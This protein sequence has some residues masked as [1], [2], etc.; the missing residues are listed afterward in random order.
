MI[1]TS[2]WVSAIGSVATGLGAGLG[3]WAAL[4][5]VN[6]WRIEALG[7][8]KAEL[9]EEVLA[10]FYRARDALI[11]ARLP[12]GGAGTDV[13]ADDGAQAAARDA[14][15]MAAP[16]E[17]LNQASQ[18]F[19]ELQASRY[20][21]MAYFGED[22]AR[23][24]DDLRKVHN[25]VVE[26]SARLIR[27]Q[28]KPVSEGDAADQDVWRNTIGWGAHGQDHLADR[29]ERAVRTIERICRPLIEEPK[30]PRSRL[31]HRL[32]GDRGSVRN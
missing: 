24:F 29:L 16:I 12:A 9:A 32:R 20:R 2:A 1:L 10:Q 14:T 8:R 30:T 7:R 26:A 3:G 6:A 15:A 5:G 22:A 25:E 11:W 27:A 4:R 21:F 19:S 31:A 13:P 23:P 28:G 17:R 18:V